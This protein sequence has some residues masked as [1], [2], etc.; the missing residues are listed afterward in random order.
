VTAGFLLD[1]FSEET[2]RVEI[3]LRV[4][5][6]E[7]GRVP[8]TPREVREMS[9]V[10]RTLPPET[11]VYEEGEYRKTFSR[12][13]YFELGWKRMYLGSYL[14]LEGLHPDVGYPS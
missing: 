5:D 3:R 12:E 11:V 13:L 10:L 14:L 4:F 8:M 1:K 7:F 2:C 9:E 6:E